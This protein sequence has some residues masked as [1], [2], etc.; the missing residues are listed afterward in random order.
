[1]ASVPVLSVVRQRLVVAALSDTIPVP[2]RR[3]GFVLDGATNDQA[4]LRPIGPLARLLAVAVTGE[5]DPRIELVRPHGHSVFVAMAS[6]LRWSPRS[7]L[8]VAT[9]PGQLVQREQ[10]GAHRVAVTVPAVIDGG[11]DAPAIAAETRDISTTGV[12]LLVDPS[13]PELPAGT[14]VG[15]VLELPDGTLTARAI[16]VATETA[17][18]AVVRM[19]IR[20]DIMADDQRLGRFLHQ[21]ELSRTRVAAS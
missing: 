21:V 2:A 14:E 3:G 19:A 18:R 11:G 15:V 8:L 10:R 1:M 7:R 17:E 9:N 6:A 5:E 16:V 20:I 4:L 12:A 13:M